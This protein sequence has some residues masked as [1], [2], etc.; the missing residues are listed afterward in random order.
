MRA[1]GVDGGWVFSA[2]LADELV[3]AVAEV[4]HLAG[5]KDAAHSHQL[6]VVRMVLVV[7]VVVPATSSCVGITSS[8]NSFGHLQGFAG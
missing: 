3:E 1:P 2:A 7:V 8:P 4:L 6:A 5:S